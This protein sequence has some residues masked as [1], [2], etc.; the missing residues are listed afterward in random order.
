M[1][2]NEGWKDHDLDGGQSRQQDRLHRISSRNFQRSDIVGSSQRSHA[3]FCTNKC[4]FSPWLVHRDCIML[5]QA[6]PSQAPCSRSRSH[7]RAEV[8]FAKWRG[9][10]T[11]AHCASV[12]HCPQPVHT[13]QKECFP[14]QSQVGLHSCGNFH[15][16]QMWPTMACIQRA[17]SKELIALFI[18]MCA[19]HRCKLSLPGE[20]GAQTH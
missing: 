11:Q 17:N 14:T 15:K 9:A 13:A 1:P 10:G 12:D 8:G 16:I 18:S 6:K 5:E 7:T 3:S 20:F 4:H 2:G 19:S